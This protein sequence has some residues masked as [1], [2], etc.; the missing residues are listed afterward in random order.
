MENKWL[1]AAL[2][3]LLIHGSIGT[4]YAWSVFKQA[5]ADDIGASVANVEWAFSIAILF[6]GLSAAALGHFVEQ[7]IK[8]SAILATIFF[9]DGDD[10][11]RHQYSTKIIARDLSLLWCGHG[12]WIRDWVFNTSQKFD[13]MV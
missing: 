11:H 12:H 1:R 3:A 7:D 13:V 10:W 6:L 9:C 2:P 8:K 4:V 5:I